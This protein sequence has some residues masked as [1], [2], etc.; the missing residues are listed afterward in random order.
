MLK[1][2]QLIPYVIYN[3]LYAENEI[4]LYQTHAEEASAKANTIRTE[5]NKTKIEA[6]R[7]GNEAEKLHQ[8]VDITDT[9]MKEYEKRSGQDTNI[10]TEVRNQLHVLFIVIII[11]YDNIITMLFNHSQANH[12]V[13]LAKINVTLASQQLDKALTEVA[14]IIK[15]LENLPEIGTLLFC[16]IIF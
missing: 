9:M 8:R 10:T 16:I 12:K 15:E 5:A 1:L 14:E 3:L 2:V 7:V 4:C 6:L 11:L 13:S